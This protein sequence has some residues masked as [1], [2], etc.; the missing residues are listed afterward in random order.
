[1]VF[2]L[3]GP[4]TDG[5]YSVTEFAMAPRPAPGPPLHVHAVEEETIYLIA[6]QLRVTRH[7]QVIGLSGGGIA[8]VPKG[9][10]HMLANIGADAARLLIIQSPPGAERY[11]AKAA[12]LMA[13]SGGSPDPASMQQL[14]LDHHIH[15]SEPRRFADT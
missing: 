9:V 2:L 15:F 7:E 12:E 8:H 1:V 3:D 10:P 4:D 6:G 13:A 14:A 5:K 11:W